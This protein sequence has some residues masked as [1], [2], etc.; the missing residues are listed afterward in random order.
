M[1]RFLAHVNVIVVV[2]RRCD[3]FTGH[4]R[5]RATDPQD[6]AGL[7]PYL[8]T[9]CPVW[10]TKFFCTARV[11]CTFGKAACQDIRTRPNG[12]IRPERPRRLRKLVEDRAHVLLPA[13]EDARGPDS[14]KNTPNTVGLLMTLSVCSPSEKIVNLSGG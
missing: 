4:G 1:P 11:R 14:L 12:E 6:M 3:P 7:S 13:L 10:Q 8:K 2:H 5:R 9:E